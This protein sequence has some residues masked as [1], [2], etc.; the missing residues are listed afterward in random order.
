MGGQEKDSIKSVARKNIMKNID[1]V[2]NEIGLS[3][4]RQIFI[5]FNTI[6]IILFSTYHTVLS[7]FTF[8]VPSW[9]CNEVCFNSMFQQRCHLARAEWRYVAD[10][11]YSFVTEYDL[12]CEHAYLAALIC[13]SFFV[14]MI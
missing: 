3:S 12:D 4:V 8:A 2:L 5:Q 9:K 11:K 14:G 7:Y 10:E 13:S 1:A 6:C